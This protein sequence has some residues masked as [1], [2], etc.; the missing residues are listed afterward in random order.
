MEAEDDQQ[1]ENDTMDVT[2]QPNPQRRSQ[3]PSFT[4][5]AT[6]QNVEQQ[7][8]GTATI[9]ITEEATEETNHELL[10]L[11]L[12]ARPTVTW[13]DFTLGHFV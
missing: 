4:S 9:T 5:A 8:T 10:T 6:S 2:E 7:A 3:P 12:R 1:E 13:Y 11:T